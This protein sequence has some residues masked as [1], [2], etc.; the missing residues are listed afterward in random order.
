MTPR[1]TAALLIALILL[2]LPG[3]PT[4]KSGDKVL[5]DLMF[6]LQLVPTDGQA[7]AAFELERLGDGKKVTLAQHRGQPMMLYF[8]ATW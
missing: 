4:A 3:A 7:P 6:E 2:A 8:W 1:R 5:D